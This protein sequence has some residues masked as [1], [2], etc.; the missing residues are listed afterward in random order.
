MNFQ[1]SDIHTLNDNEI[2]T[3]YEETRK[4]LKSEIK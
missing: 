3:I 1:F 4:K 2:R